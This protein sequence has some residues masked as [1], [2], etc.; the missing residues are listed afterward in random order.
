VD[1]LFA[2]SEAELLCGYR[3]YR[4]K[5]AAVS[6]IHKLHPASD[7]GEERIVG[8][9][10]YVDARLDAG[11]ALTNDNRSAGNKFAAKGLYAQALCI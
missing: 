7:L 10:P 2:D 6:A 5:P 9:N 3:F 8:A 11:A 4:G 1:G